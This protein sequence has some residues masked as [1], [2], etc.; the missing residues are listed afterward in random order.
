MKSLKRAYCRKAAKH[1]RNNEGARGKGKAQKVSK[2]GVLDKGSVYNKFL[3]SVFTKFLGR[4]LV[5]WIIGN[6][7]FFC[8]KASG[9]IELI[10]E[11]LS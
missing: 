7:N 11:V 5:Q 4:F 6:W 2:P 3:V 10:M 8:E 1:V 9:I